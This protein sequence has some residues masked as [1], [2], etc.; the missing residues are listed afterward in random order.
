MTRKITKHPDVSSLTPTALDLFRQAE[1]DSFDLGIDWFRL[2]VNTALGVQSRAA[3]YVLSDEDHVYCILPVRIDDDAE[4]F[5]LTTFYT[6]LFRPLLA[7]QA[8]ASDLS[9]LIRAVMRESAAGYIRLDALSTEHRS[10][11]VTFDAMRRAG[12]RPYRYFSHANWYRPVAGMSFAEYFAALSSRVRNTVKRREKK[13]LANGK[14]RIVI[15]SGDESALK[16]AVAAWDQVYAASWKRSEP[17]PAFMPGLIELGARRGW[18]RMGIAYYEEKPIAA[19]IWLVNAGR[20]AIYKLAYDEA[21]KKY[22]AGTILTARLMRHV[23]DE[24]KVH[25]V[26][27]LTG[28]DGYKQDW[29]SCRREREGIIAFDLK[30]LRGLRGAASQILGGLIKR[31]KLR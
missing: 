30:T 3:F 31:L 29:M 5:G 13:L 1:S 24:D 18:L 8:T 23:L 21:F 7:E 15:V 16:D 22:S 6:S 4:L 25:E 11:S 28:D 27:Y 2:L 17:F 14:G 12:L 10:F 26:D 9:D 20:A 19:Q